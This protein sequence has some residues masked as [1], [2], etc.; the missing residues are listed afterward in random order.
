MRAVTWLLAWAFLLAGDFSGASAQAPEKAKVAKKAGDAG[1]AAPKATSPAKQKSKRAARPR[2]ATKPS[3]PKT[4]ANPAAQIKA[5]KGFRVELL[6]SVPRDTQGSWVNMTVNPRGR[7]IVSD[8][9]G[10]LYRVTAPSAEGKAE[11][12]VVEPIDVAIGEA[13]GLLWAFDSLYVVVNRGRQYDSGLYR[14]L[15]TNGDDKLDKVEL[16]AQARRRWRARSARRGP[17]A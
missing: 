8:Q 6:Y 10:K 15:D 4:A 12:I 7:L 5:P 3:D 17:G 2:E 13:H 11:S 9:Y 16:L 14:V 1:G